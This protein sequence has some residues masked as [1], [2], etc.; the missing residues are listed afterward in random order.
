MPGSNCSVVKCGTSRRTKG[1]GIFKLPYDK[2]DDA[3]HQVWRKSWLGAILSYREKD[4]AFN[5]QIKN[6]NVYVCEKH[7]KEDDLET[8]K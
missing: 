8:C 7:F 5:E 6:G 2:S 1:V 4:K 3:A